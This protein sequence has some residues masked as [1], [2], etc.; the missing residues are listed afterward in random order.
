[1][2]TTGSSWDISTIVIGNIVDILHIR[3]YNYSDKIPVT[4]VDISPK[5][6]FHLLGC[7]ST[8]VFP[9]FVNHG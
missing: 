8:I 5:K 9:G 4:I 1:M 6:K 3:L 7:I 2:K